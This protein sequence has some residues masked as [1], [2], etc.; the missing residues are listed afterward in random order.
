[1]GGWNFTLEPDARGADFT[2]LSFDFR[3]LRLT[4]P[5]EEE[6]GQLPAGTPALEL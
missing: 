6:A 4:P 5:T 1:M 2:D 3:G